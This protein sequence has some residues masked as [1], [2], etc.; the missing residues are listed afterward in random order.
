MDLVCFDTH[1]IIWGVRGKASLGQEDSIKKAKYLI[2][3]CEQDGI[4]IMVPSVV[5]AEVLCALEPRLH[6]SVSELMH[7]RFIVPPFD[8]QAALHFA[9][10]WRNN[11]QLKDEGRISI[12]RA[13]MKADSMIIATALARGANCIYSEDTGLKKIAQDY[14]DVKS[15][16]N[17]EMQM[18]I[19]DVLQ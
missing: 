3:K 17:V 11:K 19:E 4:R 1:I 13:E 6:S 14:I 7:R 15:L 18:S 2:G 12:S 10:V 16:P 8:T 9:E 5:V